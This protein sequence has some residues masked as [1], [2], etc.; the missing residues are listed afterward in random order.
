MEISEMTRLKN[1]A[2]KGGFEVFGLR[3]VFNINRGMNF[4]F[5]GERCH[6][7]KLCLEER[8][9]IFLP[10]ITT[11]GSLNTEETYLFL[12]TLLLLILFSSINYTS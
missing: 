6:F 1:K 4:K 2:K 11:F 3:V 8:V 10:I 7:D 12:L 9:F 5:L